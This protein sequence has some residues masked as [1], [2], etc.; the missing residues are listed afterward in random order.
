M[1][2]IRLNVEMIEE[3]FSTT[4]E[5]KAVSWSSYYDTVDAELDKVVAD[6]NAWIAS[7][8]PTSRE[9]DQ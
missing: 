8:R 6:A 5:P 3:E 4:R 1:I 9:A 7:Q 2:R